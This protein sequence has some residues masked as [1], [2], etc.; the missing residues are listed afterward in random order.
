MKDRNYKLKEAYDNTDKKRVTVFL[1]RYP[2]SLSH[3]SSENYSFGLIL[4]PIPFRLGVANSL[5][6]FSVEVIMLMFDLLHPY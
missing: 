4:Q 5:P 1:F 2:F 6:S 3:G